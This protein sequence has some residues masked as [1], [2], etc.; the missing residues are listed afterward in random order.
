MT[1]RQDRFCKGFSVFAAA[2]LTLGLVFA[3]VW[4]RVNSAP[5]VTGAPPQPQG[6][7]V[8]NQAIASAAITPGA[9]ALSPNPTRAIFN[10]NASA[11]NITIQ[12]ATDTATVVWNNVQP[13]AVLP[14]AATF[15]TASTCSNLVALY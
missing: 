15:V 6:Q 4:D 13:G 9:T 5:L 2:I 8:W 12:L 7:I 10:G 1:P 14:I 3:S 11:C